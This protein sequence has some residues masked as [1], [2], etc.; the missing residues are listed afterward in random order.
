LS[1]AEGRGPSTDLLGAHISIAGG[2]HNAPARAKAIRATAMQIFT[3]MAN[4]W[5]ERVCADEECVAFR[6]ALAATDVR[7]TMAHDSYLINLASPDPTLRRQSI[8]SFVAELRRCEALGLDILV[9]HPGNHMSDMESGI[10]RNA[11]AI[12]EA[13][14]RVPGRCVIAMEGTAGSGTSIGSRFEELAALIDRVPEPHRSR[15]GVCLDTCHLYSA[16]HDL[17]KDFDAVWQRFD[18]VVGRDRLRAMH[19][20]DSKTRFASHND[21]HELIGKGTLGPKPFQR[22]MRDDRFRNVP[23]VIETPK[24]EETVTDRRMLV[25]LRA[26]GRLPRAPRR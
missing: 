24:L 19:L 21:R 6:T 26:Y 20:N 9:S 15:M 10:A 18:D 25:R 5:A 2:T 22:I 8:E 11:D 13:M 7:V 1:R 14:E 12:T 3:K 17:V 4:R 16:G 23:K